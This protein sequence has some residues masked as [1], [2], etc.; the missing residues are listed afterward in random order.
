MKA[1]VVSIKGSRAAVLAHDGTF[2]EIKNH[3]YSIGQILDYKTQNPNIVNFASVHSAKIAAAAAA[4]LLITGTVSANTYAYST[5]T[6]DVNPSLRY[7]LNVFDRVIGFDSYNTDGK[8]IVSDI[9]SEV[10]G[11]KIDNALGITLDALDESDYISEDT[12][13]V[14]TVSSHGRKDDT[15]KQKAVE[16]MNDWNEK[17]LPDNK[18]ISGNAVIITK[19]E[20]KDAK[21]KNESPGRSIL[22]VIKDQ[23]IENMYEEPQPSE[24]DMIVPEEY[25]SR[26]PQDADD[27]SQP[28]QENRD[29][30]EPEDLDRKSPD[31]QRSEPP[32][33]QGSK[34]PSD[35]GAQPPSDQGSQPP[36]D[37]GAQPPS[38][39]GSQPPS[40]QGAQPPSDQGSQPPS[41]QGAQPPSD[42]GSTPPSD[43][44]TQD[45]GGQ[46]PQAP[47]AEGSQDPGNP[48]GPDPGGR[49]PM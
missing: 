34:L 49:P 46:E 11:K 24:N 10:L 23:N 37:Q 5:V 9:R 42:H 19:D 21:E 41:D 1:T 43:Q 12:P 14:V 18:S 33:D 48:G 25:G 28:E 30:Q 6:L 45:P 27:H 44:G 20:L 36:S 26:K 38:D 39:Q 4:V 13:V 35:Q 2:N 40:D 7:E 22:N 47:P 8:E 29:M 16:E 15:L 31:D 32:G 17:N 3:D